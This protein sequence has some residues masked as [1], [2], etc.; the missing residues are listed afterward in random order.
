[1]TGSVPLSIAFV[2][3]G[4]ATLNPCGFPLL[5]AYLSFYVGADEERLP[6]APSRLLQGL[7]AGLLVTAGFLGVFAII[8][9]PIV[10]GAGAVADAVPWVGLAIGVILALAGLVAL[11]TGRLTLGVRN[12]LRI[13]RDRGLTAM[14]LFGAGYGIA[15]LGCTLPLFLALVGASL[16]AASGDS[17]LVFA[18]YGLGMALVLTALSVAAALARQGIARGLRRVVPHMSRIAGALLLAAGAYVSYYWLRL[19]LGDKATLADDPL[20]GFGTRFTAR[21]EV[22]ARQD[23][24]LIITAAGIAV[25]LALTAGLLQWSRRR[26]TAARPARDSNLTLRGE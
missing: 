10:Y 14:I 26:T 2:A 16:G 1:M 20:V 9:L 22:I 8:G 13:A 23:R 19:E 11:S 6:S 21:L 18:A 12:P 3:G 4:L 15:S 7:L 17:L 24:T 25:A 5:P